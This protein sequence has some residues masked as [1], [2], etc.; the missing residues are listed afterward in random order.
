MNLN[1][2]LSGTMIGSE[3]M[4]Q[5]PS[6]VKWPFHKGCQRPSENRYLHYGS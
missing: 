2:P 5:E 4:G 3:A 1:E 6:G